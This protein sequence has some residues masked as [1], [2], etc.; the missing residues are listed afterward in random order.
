MKL[1]LSKI[2]KF[3]PGVKALHNINF[4]L[5]K[6]SIHA[7]IGENGAGKSTL[8]KILCG[9]YQ[10]DEGIINIDSQKVQIADP[11]QSLKYGISAIHQESVMFDELTVMENIFIGNHLLKKN[12]L[13]DWN[14]MIARSKKILSQLNLL[15]GVKCMFY[16][17]FVSTDATIK[18][19]N[20]MAL[21]NGFIK[22]NS[23]VVNLSAMPI[24]EKGEVNTL[25]ISK[26]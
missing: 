4:N 10:P 16:D 8:V 21:E 1:E 9:V 7:L 2:S 17:N 12:K 23:L 24:I 22:K 3:F 6:N 11:N 14:T 19:V 13:I 25:R 5:K 15:W 20:K 26:V 18:E